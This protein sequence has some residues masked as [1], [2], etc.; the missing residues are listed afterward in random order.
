MIAQCNSL[1]RSLIVGACYAVNSCG[2][3]YC[4]KPHV[5]QGSI[6]HDTP[7]GQFRTPHPPRTVSYT[8][9]LW[10][11]IVHPISQCN[12]VHHMQWR[13]CGERYSYVSEYV[14]PVVWMYLNK[15]IC[16]VILNWSLLFLK[17]HVV[18][19]AWSFDVPIARSKECNVF[20][21]MLCFMKLL[22]S[23]MNDQM[24][25]L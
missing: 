21:P 19:N 5:L 10:G 12:I 23:Q 16:F 14:L 25:S 7:A 20:V 6:V 15:S 2:W 4:H 9:F 17:T 3:R 22:Q 8:T 11:S 1:V 18:N 13:N 24:Y